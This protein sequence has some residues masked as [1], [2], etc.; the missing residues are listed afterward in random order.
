MHR[1][2]QI[3]V[4]REAAIE[5]LAE[6]G[7]I[8][9][10]MI[11]DATDMPIPAAQNAIKRLVKQGILEKGQKKFDGH[12]W[13]DMYVMCGQRPKQACM[14]PEPTFRDSLVS[15]LFGNETRDPEA[16]WAF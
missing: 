15:A 13:H 1:Q 14:I 8:S 10:R 5:L 2:H 16:A 6:E 4:E 12:N 9:M 7:P 3:A 11:V